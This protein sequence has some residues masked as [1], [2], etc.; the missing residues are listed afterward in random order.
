MTKIHTLKIEPIHYGAIIDGKKKFEIRKNDR[1]FNVG[2]IIELKPFMHGCY[3]KLMPIRRK[4][5]YV[6]NYKQRKN[7]VVLSI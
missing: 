4:I 5:L 3:L 2:D 6:S 7:Y 1:G